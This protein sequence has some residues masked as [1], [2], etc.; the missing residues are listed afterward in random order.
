MQHP[1][2]L[3]HPALKIRGTRSQLGGDLGVLPELVECGREG[4]AC[5]EGLRVVV[6]EDAPSCCDYS[7]YAVA[8]SANRPWSY[9]SCARTWRVFSVF[10]VLAEDAPSRG[11]HL[12]V[13]GCRPFVMALLVPCLGKVHASYE[14]VGVFCP[15]HPGLG[16]DDRLSSRSASSGRPCA[17]SVPASWLRVASLPGWSSPKVLRR[18]SRTPGRFRARVSIWPSTPARS[19]ARSSASGD[20]GRHRPDHAASRATGAAAWSG[21]HL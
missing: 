3:P 16:F 15:E 12:G 4:M 21:S 11:E 13:L 10:G 6:A 19:C 2:G 1:P 9:Q 14:G 17:R 5:G 18:A 7:V 8:A 20:P